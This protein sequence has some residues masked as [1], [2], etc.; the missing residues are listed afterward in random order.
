MSTCEKDHSGDLPSEFNDL[1]ESQAA[2]WRHRC[3]ACAYELGR[4]DVA[5]AEERLRKRVRE[6]TMIVKELTNGRRS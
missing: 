2:K 4:R 5:G 6:L 1:P 3:A